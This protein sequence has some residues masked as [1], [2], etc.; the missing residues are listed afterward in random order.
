MTLAKSTRSTIVELH[1]GTGASPPTDGTFDPIAEVKSFDGPSSTA[2]TIDVSS[3]DSTAVE[4][5][6]ALADAG[7]VSLGL[8][9]IGS[10]TGQQDLNEIHYSGEA[11]YFRITF[12]DHDTTPTT[13]TFLASVTGFQTSGQTNAAYELSVTLTVSGTPTWEFAP[14]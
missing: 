6:A 11:R 3:F 5:I 14:A 10:D 13:C 4:K 9:F 12:N 1:D 2:P 7:E 8:N